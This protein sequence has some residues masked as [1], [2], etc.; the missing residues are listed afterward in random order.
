MILEDKKIKVT[1]IVPTYNQEKY[2]CEA[3][4]SALAQT[5]LN[6]EVI[7]GDDASTDNTQEIIK[8]YLNKSNIK[9]IRNSKNLGRVENYR[10]LLYKHATGDFVV[11]LDGDDYFTDQ[12]FIS[13]AIKLIKDR[14]EVMM[15]VAKATTK[16]SFEEY[17][18]SIPLKKEM[19]GLDILKAL[20][21]RNLFLMHM[22]TLYHRKKAI[23]IDFYRSK[24]NSTDWESLYRLCLR[25]T[26]EFL[27]RNI[28]VWRIHGN[29]ESAT[30][31]LK[32][33]L[34][35]L[36]IWPLIY[37]DARNFGMNYFLAKY[38]C[39]KCISYITQINCA[40]ISKG[41]RIFVFSYIISVAKKYQFAILL[42]LVN[43]ISFGRIAFS[44][45]G[46]YQRKNNS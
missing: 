27:D 10:N 1:I 31:D 5:Y 33:L 23:E 41:G 12:D 42:I 34:L 16:S 24:A 4:D 18:S 22:A 14:Q 13:E 3:I 44:F 20:P 19:L 32:K 39:A 46:Y 26:V 35:N 37:S 9:L 25:G 38:R 40:T 15:V 30:T 43:P 7:V 28:G 8:K 2:I 29:N 21:D 45:L 11:N 36:S 6:L 17:E